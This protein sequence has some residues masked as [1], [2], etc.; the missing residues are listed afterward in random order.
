MSKTLT[1]AQVEEWAPIAKAMFEARKWS[2]ETLTPEEVKQ[3][4]QKY[5]AF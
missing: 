5:K 3:Q 2:D 4:A 1:D